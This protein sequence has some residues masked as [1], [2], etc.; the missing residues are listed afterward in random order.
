[1]ALH[2]CGRQRMWMG[3]CVLMNICASSGQII[4]IPVNIT[5]GAEVSI[6]TLGAIGVG[7]VA[8]LVFMICSKHL[9]SIPAL[10]FAYIAV[11]HDGGLA[12]G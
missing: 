1:M 10:F 4:I 5:V 12:R 3:A 9:F 8:P 7:M 6:Q 2:A 11:I